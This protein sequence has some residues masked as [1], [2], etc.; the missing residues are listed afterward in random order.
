[1][2]LSQNVLREQKQKLAELDDAHRQREGQLAT[3]ERSMNANK[4]VIMAQ[5]EEAESKLQRELINLAKQ[6]EVL[7]TREESLNR[8]ETSLNSQA[9]QLSKA[10]EQL[11]RDRGQLES[12]ASAVAAKEAALIKEREDIN[13]QKSQI[14][15]SSKK[16]VDEACEREDELTAFIERLKRMNEK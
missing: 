15:E 11:S 5:I 12:E 3:R 7:I 16:T 13:W 1:M 10:M 2:T 8:R 4:D 6:T 14:I 9:D